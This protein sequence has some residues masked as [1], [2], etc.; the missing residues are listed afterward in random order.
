MTTR[1]SLKLSIEHETSIENGTMIILYIEETRGYTRYVSHWRN[2]QISQASLF[3]CLSRFDHV[4]RACAM[5]VEWQ[6]QM[7][8]AQ[9]KR[10]SLQVII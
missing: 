8:F 6:G 4:T 1:V 5:F 2:R 7:S 9:V 3:S 10:V